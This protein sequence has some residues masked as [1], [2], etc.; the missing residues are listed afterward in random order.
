MKS[1]FN[2]NRP[3]N[4]PLSVNASLS[5]PTLLVFLVEKLADRR[6]SIGYEQQAV[7]PGWHAIETSSIEA[8]VSGNTNLSHEADAIDAGFTT[9][10]IFSC[11]KAKGEGYSFTW[12]C[13]L[14]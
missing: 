1:Q 14:S 3:G 2:R 13:S 11:T 6:N 12:L 5:D 8:Y 4:T 7:Q 9:S 10:F